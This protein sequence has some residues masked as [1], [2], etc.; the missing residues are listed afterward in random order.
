MVGGITKQWKMQF[1]SYPVQELALEVLPQGKSHHLGARE[2][3]ECRICNRH[4]GDSCRMFWSCPDIRELWETVLHVIESIIKSEVTRNTTW[5][6]LRETT[7]L[8]WINKKDA[9][10]TNVSLGKKEIKSRHERK[11]KKK[12]LHCSHTGKK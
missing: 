8:Q 5:C 12:I 2:H 4:V 7:G 11:E 10:D 6:Y 9:V 3:N 1:L